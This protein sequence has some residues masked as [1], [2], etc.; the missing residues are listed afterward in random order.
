MNWFSW[1]FCTERQALKNKLLP[2]LA[3]LSSAGIASTPIKEVWGARAI[4][5]RDSEENRL[6][7][8][9]GRAKT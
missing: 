6:E 9:E 7:F 8:W 4:Y 5:V 1:A 2:V 3:D